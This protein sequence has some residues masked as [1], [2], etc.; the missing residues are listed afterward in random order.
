MEAVVRYYLLTTFA[1]KLSQNIHAGESEAI[2]TKSCSR[3]LSQHKKLSGE[4][5]IT[6]EGYS[7]TNQTSKNFLWEKLTA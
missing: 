1:T 7:E 6:T 2:S 5:M 3:Y 4:K